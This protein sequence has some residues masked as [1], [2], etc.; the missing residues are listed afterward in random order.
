MLAVTSA[1]GKLGSAVLDNLLENDFVDKKDL[2]VCTSSDPSTDKLKPLLE[3]GLTVRYANFDDPSSLTRAFAGCSKLFLVSTPS[4]SM[5]YNDAPLWS[6]RELHHRRAIDAA[7]EAGVKHIYYTSLAFANPSKA[8]VMRAHIRTEAYLAKECGDITWTVLRE[9]LYNESWPL[10]FGYYFGLKDEQRKEIVVAGD[11]PVSWTSISDMAFATAKIISS[12]SREW[13]GK[14]LYLSQRQTCTLSDIAA[15]V[16]KV[17]GEEVQLKVVSRKDYETYYVQEMGKEKPS[18]EWW[19]ST[20]DALKDREC[21]I[22]DGTLEDILKEGYN[23]PKPL[24]ETV[25]EM[26]K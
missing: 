4:I 6:G 19:S 2:V 15:I 1:T 21:D 23:K 14:T 10:Y 22:T 18:V 20:Y 26:L 5:D 8:S 9:G 11:G 24:A 16:S 12:S 25:E 7:R 3:R 17:K 13:A